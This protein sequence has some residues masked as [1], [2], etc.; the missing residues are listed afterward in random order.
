[1]TVGIV[2]NSERMIVSQIVNNIES[3]KKDLTMMEIP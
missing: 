2:D 3:L 1:M